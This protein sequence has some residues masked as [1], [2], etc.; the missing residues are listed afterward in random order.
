MLVINRSLAQPGDE[1]SDCSHARPE[2]SDSRCQRAYHSQASESCKDAACWSGGPV[3][4]A[5]E[6]SSQRTL[7]IVSCHL[8]LPGV[9]GNLP[10][11]TP[12]GP[13]PRHGTNVTTMVSV[14]HHTVMRTTISG[15][16]LAKSALIHSVPRCGLRDCAIHFAKLL[17]WFKTK[18]QAGFLWLMNSFKPAVVLKAPTTFQLARRRQ[19]ATVHN[20][21]RKRKRT[22]KEDPS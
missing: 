9:G 12:D 16:V 10:E 5:L 1:C 19:G 17:A 8:R 4:P 3:C 13:K 6:S 20:I 22:S 15:F 2:K 18:S 14:T 21:A 7:R 11:I